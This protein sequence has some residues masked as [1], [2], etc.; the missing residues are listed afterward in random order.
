MEFIVVRSDQGPLNLPPKDGDY[1]KAYLT[2][3]QNRV[4]KEVALQWD[5]K[6]SRWF[7]GRGQAVAEK[8]IT[9]WEKK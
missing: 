5:A 2:L 1:Y 8:A 9:A 4:L 7:D 6:Y 3:G